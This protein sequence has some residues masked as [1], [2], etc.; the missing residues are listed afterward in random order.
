MDH[1]LITLH[2]LLVAM[3]LVLAF[4]LAVHGQPVPDDFDGL[5]WSPMLALGPGPGVGPGPGPGGPVPPGRGGDAPWS[6]HG[7]GGPEGA[8]PL[9]PS[10][11]GLSLTEAQRDKVFAVLHGQAPLLREKSKIARRAQDELRALTISPQY[12]KAK[13]QSLADAGARALGELALVRADGEHQIYMALTDE[14]REQLEMIQ[15][16]ARRR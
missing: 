9:L 14:Q 13:A 15:R 16:A 3:G 4:P 10:L 12:D 6:P 11:S 1:P 5:L 2:R 8:M 7:F